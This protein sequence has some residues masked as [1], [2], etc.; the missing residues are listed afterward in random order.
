MTI[1]AKQSPRPF[2]VIYRGAVSILLLIIF[3]AS[4]LAVTYANTQLTTVKEQ[5]KLDQ[6]TKDKIITWICDTLNG[7]YVYPDVAKKMERHIQD[8]SKAGKYNRISDIEEFTQILTKD[9]R[10]IC[11]D[12]HLRVRFNPNPPPRCPVNIRLS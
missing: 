1:T 5:S 8:R 4:P 7:N 6:A 2:N 12:K 3:I 9:L 10:S 11:K